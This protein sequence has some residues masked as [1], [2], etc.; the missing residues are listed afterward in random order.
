MLLLRL[1]CLAP[2]VSLFE[3]AQDAISKT[4]RK[5][6]RRTSFLKTSNSEAQKAV[7]ATKQVIQD[8][9]ITKTQAE[10]NDMEGK[11][12]VS[13]FQK[14]VRGQQ[15]LKRARAAMS[16]LAKQQLQMQSALRCETL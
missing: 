9:L 16:A 3:S 2:E 1:V 4:L 6:T 7:S 13:E 5:R 14:S 12:Q 15:V 8:F 11:Q 10:A